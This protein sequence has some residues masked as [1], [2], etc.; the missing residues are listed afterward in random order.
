MASSGCEPLEILKRIETGS[1]D[2]LIEFHSNSADACSENM[3]DPQAA[4][5]S[6]LR[7]LDF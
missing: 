7:T 6:H 1:R 3:N 4:C 2:S 5:F